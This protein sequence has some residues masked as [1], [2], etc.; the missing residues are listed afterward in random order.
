VIGTVPPDVLKAMSARHALCDE[1]HGSALM[2]R[3][4]AARLA[5]EWQPIA[6]VPKDGTTVLVYLEA[7]LQKSRVHA[8]RFSDHVSVIATSFA[9]DAPKATHW[10]P[11]LDAPAPP[12]AAAA[13]YG[14]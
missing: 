3:G 4:A 13:A 11:M 7:P 14:V 8:A 6:T 10:R 1:L 2:A 12:A 5:P 9:F